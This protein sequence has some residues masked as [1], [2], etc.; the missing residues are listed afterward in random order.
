MAF[1]LRHFFK[2]ARSSALLLAVMALGPGAL[3]DDYL[4]VS[5]TE[6]TPTYQYKPSPTDWRDINIYQL[7]TD[8]FFDGDPSNN[9]T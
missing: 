9:T 7:I 4:L 8:R 6:T 5:R 2:S 3:A 1:I